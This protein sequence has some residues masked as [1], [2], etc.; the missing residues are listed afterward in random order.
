[1]AA[2]VAVT[3][4]N[5]CSPK[6]DLAATQTAMVTNTPTPTNTI[7]LTPTETPTLTPTA[8]ETPTPTA[9]ATPTETMTP[10]FELNL[11]I[12][13]RATFTIFDVSWSGPEDWCPDRGKN[14]TCETEYRNYS[15]SCVVGMTCYDACGFYYAVDTLPKGGGAY[16]FS[17][18]CY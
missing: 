7:T 17:G 14:V 3:I 18:P 10:T 5:A 9:S 11:P 8:T 6:P 15:G 16:T 1:M 4:L 12:M 13:P 2:L